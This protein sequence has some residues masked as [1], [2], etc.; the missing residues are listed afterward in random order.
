MPLR[1]SRVAVAVFVIGA[2]T[3][4]FFLPVSHNEILYPL[5]GLLGLGAV[6]AI[7]RRN[8]LIDTHVWAI[9]F[10]V[11]ALG[12]YGSLLGNA[13]PDPVFTIA[14]YLA[15]PFFYLACVAAVTLPTLRHVMIA[16]V[17]GTIAVSGVLLLFIAGEARVLPQLVPDFVVTHLDLKATF[18]DGASQARSWGLSSLVALGPIWV[19]SL[20]VRRHFLLPPW[21]LRLL[22]AVLAFATALL[23][24]RSAIVLVMVLA[25]VIALVLR[26]TLFRTRPLRLPRVGHPAVWIAGAAVVVA[27][28]VVAIP[29]LLTIG[30]IGAVVTSIASF[31]GA[32]EASGDADQS[33]RSDQ[34]WY[35]LQGWAQ[36]PIFGAGFRADIPDY[37]RASE[38]PWSLELQYHVLLFSVGLVGVSIAIAAVL[39]GLHYLRTAVKVRPVAA[40][41]L[42]VTTTGAFAMLI[43]NATNPYLVAPGHQWALFLPLAVATVA[44]QTARESAAETSP[45]LTG[46]ADAEG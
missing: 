3:W 37:A 7:V 24:D 22:C 20:L 21:W 26:F 1:P 32:V 40:P 2:F 19:A 34:A 9:A 10:L 33:I 23:S 36:N 17:I 13:N 43:A 31:F 27:G 12:L 4:I 39:V 38:I 44:L 6:A 28:V 29:R 35:I 15:A 14:V 45:A 42:V 18:R 16:A 41:I 11:G 25:P 30:P 8:P 5:F 46:T